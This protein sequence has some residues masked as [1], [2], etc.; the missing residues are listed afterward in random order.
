MPKMARDLEQG[1]P[2]W[3]DQ[4]TTTWCRGSLPLAWDHPCEIW[5]IQS[6]DEDPL[7]N[8]VPLRPPLRRLWFHHPR[9]VP[10]GD[11]VEFDLPHNEIFAHRDRSS[12]RPLRNPYAGFRD[13]PLLHHDTSRAPI[14]NATLPEIGPPPP[15]H[16]AKTVTTL[17]G[18]VLLGGAAYAFLPSVFTGTN[19]DGMWQD[20]W[21]H[22]KR[23]WTQPPVFDRDRAIVNYVGHPYF[24][25]S[26]YLTQRNFGESPLRSFLFSVAMSTGF[27][28]LV[29]SWAE[30][31]SVQDLI[32]TPIVGSILGELAYQA[33]QAMRKHGFTTAEKI[34]VTVLNPLYVLQNGYR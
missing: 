34:M 31:P 1:S 15:H 33:T 9:L 29:E 10:R 5:D 8:E 2:S 12:S 3:V 20:S 16:A 32:V 26:F 6:R 30:Q 11:D 13:Q 27:E 17:M 7:G 24:G 18:G 22:F 25:M 21:D 23:A 28:Y 14:T 4:A 19:K